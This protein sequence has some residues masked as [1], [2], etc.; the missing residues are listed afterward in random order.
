VPVAVAAEKRGLGTAKDA[1]ARV[2]VFGTG[3]LVMNYRLSGL[4][5]RDYNRDLVLSTIAWLADRPE[6][7]GIAPKVPQ[8]IRLTLDQGTV[9]MAFRL[10]VIALPLVCLA[11]AALVWYRRRV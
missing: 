4:L 6:R 8:Q 10:F 9:A 2:A 3:R 7:A 11:L 1:T 5:V